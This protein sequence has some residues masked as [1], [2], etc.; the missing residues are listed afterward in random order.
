MTHHAAYAAPYPRRTLRRAITDWLTEGRI[1]RLETDMSAQTDA[2][3][4][5]DAQLTGIENAVAADDEA[6]AAQVQA[7][8]SRLRDLAAA[9]NPD[10]PAPAPGEPG[11]IEPDPSAPAP[12]SDGGASEV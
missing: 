12:E 9:L 4:E 1:V 10:H 8:T 2:W 11:A 7:R 3:A 5:F 6:D